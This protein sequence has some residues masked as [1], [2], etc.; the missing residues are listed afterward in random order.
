MEL[1]FILKLVIATALGFLFF[2]VINIGIGEILIKWYMSK[3]HIEQR[4]EVSNDMGFGMLAGG[5]FLF[6]L[7]VFFPL[8]IYMTWRWLGRRKW[9]ER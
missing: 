2:L 8:G 6:D 7:V 1:K 3:Y 9:F 4:A 5:L